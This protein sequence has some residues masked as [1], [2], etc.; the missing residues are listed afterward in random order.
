MSNLDQELGL[1]KQELNNTTSMVQQG[2]AIA[3]REYTLRETELE[4]EGRRLDLDTAALRAKED[5]AKADQAITELRNKTRNEIQADLADA[6]Q[7][8]QGTAAR[9]ANSMTIV[10]HETERL[11]GPATEAAD[12]PTNC[13]ILR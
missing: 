1:R 4:T 8:L 11:A 7:K 9:I 10:G 6:D 2:L 12:G 3:P 5:I 13:L